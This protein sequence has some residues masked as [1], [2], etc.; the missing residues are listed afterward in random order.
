MISFIGNDQVV[1]ELNSII[2]SGNVGH[3]YMFFGPDGVGKFLLA[4]EFAKEIEASLDVSIIEPENGM[5]KVDI[6]RAL[7]ENIM[8]KPT[9]SCRRA[10]IINDADTMNESAQNALLKILEEPPSYATIIL[11]TSNKEKI[12]M[13]I[14]SRCTIFNFKKLTNEELQKVFPEEKITKEM[15]DFSNGSAG[16]YLKLKNSN[17]AESMALL[18]Q[19]LDSK[20]LLELNKTI[21]NLKQIKTIKEDIDDIL[22][23]LI[24]KVGSNLLKDSQKKVKQVELIEEVRSNIK[25]N[26]NFENSLD[27]LAVRL[28]E[29]NNKK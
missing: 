21:V 1:S 22:D 6:I 13:T 10:F 12:L 20:D 17:Y 5:I 11:V 3:A 15:F 27:Y 9:I 25:R 8:L 19:V 24:I 7:S 16:K 23:L 28:W 14:K 26:A 18:E 4:K 2:S 29:I